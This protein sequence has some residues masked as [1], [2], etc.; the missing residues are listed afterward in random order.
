MGGVVAAQEIEEGLGLAGL[1]AQMQVRDEE[2]AVAP[3]PRLMLHVVFS[4]FFNTMEAE[5]K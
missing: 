2:C 5:L 1:G 3:H 4:R